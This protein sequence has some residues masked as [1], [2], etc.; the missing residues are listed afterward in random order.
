MKTISHKVVR[1]MD[2]KPQGSQANSFSVLISELH[3]GAPSETY[4]SHLIAGFTPFPPEFCR[5]L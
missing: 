2:R 3:H 5:D 4:V 1:A